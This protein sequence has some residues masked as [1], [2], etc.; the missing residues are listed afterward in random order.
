[1]SSAPRLAPSRVNWTPATAMLSAASALTG[2]VPER[3]APAAGALTETVGGVVSGGGGGPVVEL[4]E[5]RHRRDALRVHQEEHVV[6]GRG[7]RGG[8][9]GRDG[10]P[11]RRRGHGQRDQPLVHVVGVRRGAGGDQHGLRDVGVEGAHREGRAVGDLVGRRADRRAGALEQVGRREDLDLVRLAAAAGRAVVAGRDDP[12]VGQEERGRVV[13]A[14]LDLGGQA[15]PGV[16][17]RV[18]AQRV[19]AGVDEGVGA[20][21]ADRDDRAVGREDAVGVAAG[22]GKRRPEA[23]AGAEVLGV[24]HLGRRLLVARDDHHLARAVRAVRQEHARAV[25]VVDAQLRHGAPGPARR[26]EQPHVV[27]ERAGHEHPPVAHHVLERVEVEAL[28]ADG[29]DRPDPARI[30]GGGEHVDVGVDGSRAVAL[31]PAGDDDLAVGQQR[32]GGVP[33]PLVHPP[34]EA[35]RLGPGVEDVDRVEAAELRLPSSGCS[36]RRRARARRRAGSGR[37]TRCSRA[38]RGRR[39]GWCRWRGPRSRRCRPRRGRS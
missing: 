30:G 25:V 12:P 16:G 17:R 38:S 5:L 8:R 39:G 18:V 2:V 1:M 10:E 32:R 7:D 13:A 34:L 20:V 22:L 9:G 6:A 24:E 4:D 19:E 21:A 33:A 37:R 15:R 14:R 23:P 27:A 3:L 26:V 29:G 35:P 28:L 36:R 31:Q 11:T